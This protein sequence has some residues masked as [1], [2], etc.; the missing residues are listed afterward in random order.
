LGVISDGI[1]KSKAAALGFDNPYGSYVSEIVPGTA[2]EKADFK[3]FD[4]IVGVDNYRVGAEQ[5]LSDILRKYDVGDKAFIHAYRKG[6]KGGRKVTFGSRD[7]VKYQEKKQCEKPFLGI[8]QRSNNTGVS[9]VRVSPVSYSTAAD[10]GI[11]PGDVIYSLNG[12]QMV[13]WTDISIG[14][15]KIIQS[16]PKGQ[17]R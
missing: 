6:K 7:D 10:A 1:S 2:A 4:Y 5:S 17:V 15:S 8:E 11:Q 13:D 12:N 14:A 16:N 3:P 9:G